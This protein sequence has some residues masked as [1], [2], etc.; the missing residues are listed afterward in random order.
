MEATEVTENRIPI[1]IK[2]KKN[3][4][5]KEKKS[6]I[7]FA[8]LCSR[9]PVSQG[10][11]QFCYT[12]N[13]I[14]N[15][16]CKES[17]STKASECQQDIAECRGKTPFDTGKKL[18]DKRMDEK[19]F[20]NKLQGITRR[21]VKSS[22]TEQKVNTK[23]STELRDY[24]FSSSIVP[25]DNTATRLCLSAEKSTNCELPSGTQKDVIAYL[26]KKFKEL[27][28]KI[29]LVTNN[30]KILQEAS[31]MCSEIEFQ[32]NDVAIDVGD[33]RILKT[34]LVAQ[35]TNTPNIQRGKPKITEKAIGTDDCCMKVSKEVN[36]EKYTT[37]KQQSKKRSRT[38][39]KTNSK[40]GKLWKLMQKETT[41]ENDKETNTSVSCES[42][43]NTAYAENILTVEN[44]LINKFKGAV[45]QKKAKIIQPPIDTNKAMCCG[46][47][48]LAAEYQKTAQGTNMPFNQKCTC[49]TS[50]ARQIRDYQKNV[51]DCKEYAQKV[52]MQA[53]MRKEGHFEDDFRELPLSFLL[54]KP[55]HSAKLQ[56]YSRSTTRTTPSI[57]VPNTSVAPPSLSSIEEELGRD[58]KRELGEHERIDSR[59][60]LDE[61]KME[62][63]ATI[64]SKD[65]LELHHQE[66]GDLADEVSKKE[67]ITGVTDYSKEPTTLGGENEKENLNEQYHTQYTDQ[68]LFDKLLETYE[69]ENDIAER[70]SKDDE[71]FEAQLSSVKSKESIEKI[72]A[73]DKQ[74]EKEKTEKSGKHKGSITEIVA[75]RLGGDGSV[76][77]FDVIATAEE[78]VAKHQMQ[79]IEKDIKIMESKDAPKVQFSGGSLFQKEKVLALDDNLSVD[80]VPRKVIR[81]EAPLTH[82]NINVE[83]REIGKCFRRGFRPDNIVLTGEPCLKISEKEQSNRVSAEAATS[84]IDF[85]ERDTPLEFLLGLGFSVDE[86][87]NAIKDEDVKN[88]LNAAITE[89]IIFFGNTE[90][91]VAI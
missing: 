53:E 89:V 78:R 15:P 38:N 16:V 72:I 27:E 55:D 8:D 71:F 1:K 77:Q 24:G 90:F 21:L 50:L 65:S 45:T 2:I 29:D 66:T 44:V 39:E 5:H 14:V 6:L 91:S 62:E 87:S 22:R 37:K 30:T 82:N 10:V 35:T 76:D 11:V 83:P 7:T 19:R 12:N 69:R 84:F 81:K 70:L 61:R 42:Q 57:S 40:Q 56:G 68:E 26:E 59:K 32:D 33:Q 13:A 88:R 47:K 18:L 52:R 85:S 17:T 60:E 43:T 28:R 31:C 25:I 49:P 51:S 67:E 23:A 41:T 73:Q 79:E 58:K 63:D 86:A 48:K 3:N 4:D 34:V 74:Q 46:S 20:K 54:G 64:P 9:S 36:T 75:Y 80:K